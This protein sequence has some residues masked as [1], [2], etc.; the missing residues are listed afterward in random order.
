MK[1]EVRESHDGT[2]I[3]GPTGKID[4]GLEPTNDYHDIFI[5]KPGSGSGDD[6]CKISGDTYQHKKKIKKLPYGD[7]GSQ[8]TGDYWEVNKNLTSDLCAVLKVVAV[9]VC[10][11]SRAVV[12]D[13]GWKSLRKEIDID[14]PVGSDETLRLMA[15]P[16]S[17]MEGVSRSW[18]E[19]AAETGNFDSVEE[20][21]ESFGLNVIDDEEAED[22]L[23][24]PE[25]YNDENIFSTQ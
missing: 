22:K 21:A 3:S 15:G 14:D 23:D 19:D 5:Q 2:V 1:L 16:D 6:M 4:V 13:D 11:H 18:A 7:N 8:W 17:P 24:E 20:F 12:S 25:E 9:D 10:I